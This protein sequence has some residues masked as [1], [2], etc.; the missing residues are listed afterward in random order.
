MW[1]S[2][3]LHDDGSGLYNTLLKNEASWHKTCK[4]P[5][6]STKLK[7]QK[8]P[9]ANKSDKGMVKLYSTK[10][11]G[12]GLDVPSIK[13]NSSRLKERLTQREHIH[14]AET[15]CWFSIM[16][17]AI[18][19]TYGKPAKTTLIQIWSLLALI[20]T[21][22]QGPSIKEGA[23]DDKPVKTAAL[24]ISPLWAFNSCKYGTEGKTTTTS[25]H[26]RDREHPLPVY[27]A[28]KIHGETRKKTLVDAFYNLGL[29]IS[30]D[31]VLCISTDTANQ[32]MRHYSLWT[33]TCRVPS[34]TTRKHFYHSSC[35]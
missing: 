9:K 25:R 17:L 6:N 14:K 19:H 23:S 12:L 15:C 13:N 8:S 18:P 2:V 26:S 21:I 20:D 30:Y 3:N 10:L 32:C 24:T 5:V 33:G 28:L 22:L 29:C 31:S 1:S 7:T 16:P 27:T 35:G 34:K 11:Q 4:D